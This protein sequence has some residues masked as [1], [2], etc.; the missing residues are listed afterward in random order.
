NTSHTFAYGDYT[1]TLTMTDDDG[2]TGTDT[3]QL[4]FDEPQPQAD[5]EM[6]ISDM[7]YSITGNSNNWRMSV[8]LTI[9]DQNGNPVQGATHSGQFT[10]TWDNTSC[11][12]NANGQCTV[13]SSNA[14][15]WVSEIKF[16]VW[17]VSG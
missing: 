16:Q 2:L 5:P 6:I 8:T 13:R 1:V 4:S 15:S 11:T 14:Q 3:L 17:W 12:T 7:D 10:G 9:V